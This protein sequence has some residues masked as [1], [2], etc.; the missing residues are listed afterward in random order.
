MS[1]IYISASHWT[2]KDEQYYWALTEP[3]GTPRSSYT[4]LQGKLP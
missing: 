2:A 4:Y 1:A 3:N